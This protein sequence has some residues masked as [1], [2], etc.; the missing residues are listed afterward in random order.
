MLIHQNG[1]NTFVISCAIHTK[2]S[3]CISTLFTVSI[4]LP[5][6]RDWS[7]ATWNPTKVRSLT[8]ICMTPQKGGTLTHAGCQVC[9]LMSPQKDGRHLEHKWWKELAHTPRNLGSTPSWF[10]LPLTNDGAQVSLP[11]WPQ[12]THLYNGIITILLGEKDIGHYENSERIMH[13][14]KVG[15]HYSLRSPNVAHI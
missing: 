11:V 8:G 4:N 12:V 14:A 15:H 13:W 2:T 9:I 3:W 1:M 7:S 10:C 6:S 5:V